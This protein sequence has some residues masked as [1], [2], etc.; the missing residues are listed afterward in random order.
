L[1]GNKL[2]TLDS[3]FSQDPKQ[4]EKTEALMKKQW[5]AT[6]KKISFLPPEEN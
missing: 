4:N 1:R 3:G 2:R 6:I 5:E